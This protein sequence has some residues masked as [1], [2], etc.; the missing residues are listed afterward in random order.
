[1]SS[2][3]EEKTMLLEDCKRKLA[4]IDAANPIQKEYYYGKFWREYYKTLAFII[5]ELEGKAVDTEHI[6]ETDTTSVF[7]HQTEERKAEPI[8]IEFN[9]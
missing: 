7:R 9:L 1:M 2:A 8:I 4:Q 3:G 6:G 5:T